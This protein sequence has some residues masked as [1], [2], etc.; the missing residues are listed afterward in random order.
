MQDFNI[1]VH[2][3]GLD[4]FIEDEP[5]QHVKL[6]MSMVRDFCF[7]WSS[8]NPMVHYK[9]YNKAVNLPFSDFCA[10]IKVP[11]WGSCEKIKG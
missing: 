6:T 8:T 1:L 11:E 9:I 2:N 10:A 7:K 3:A 4:R 5:I